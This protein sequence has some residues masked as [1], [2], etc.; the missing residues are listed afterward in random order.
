MQ[1]NVQPTRK[2]K[3]I[4][5]NV[6]LDL[7]FGLDHRNVTRSRMGKCRSGLF[8]LSVFSLAMPH[9]ICITYQTVGFSLYLLSLLFPPSSF[10]INQANVSY[11]YIMTYTYS[12]PVCHNGKYYQDLICGRS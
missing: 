2:T 1:C 5:K 3:G 8:S 4:G 6:F 7:R 12:L 11:H 9:Y 10:Y